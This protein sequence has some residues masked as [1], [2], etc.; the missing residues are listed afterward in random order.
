MKSI[1]SKLSKSG[2]K[3]F[4]RCLVRNLWSDV[5]GSG[6]FKRAENRAGTRLSPQLVG[7]CW[8]HSKSQRAGP[9][10]LE[11]FPGPKR[12]GI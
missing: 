6:M 10:S 7:P 2:L 5:A 11:I 3:M 9:G 4:L 1:E 8:A 12:A